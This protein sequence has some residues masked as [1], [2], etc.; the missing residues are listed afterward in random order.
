MNIQIILDLVKKELEK[1]KINK[2]F[3]N[4]KK[5]SI[6]EILDE[7]LKKEEDRVMEELERQIK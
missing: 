6:K 2:E 4:T 1:D 7:I 5:K 3:K